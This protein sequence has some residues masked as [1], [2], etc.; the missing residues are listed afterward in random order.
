MFRVEGG[1]VR[2]TSTGYGTFGPAEFKEGNILGNANL[3]WPVKFDATEA[4][5]IL[6]DKGYTG[7]YTKLGLVKPLIPGMNQDHYVFTMMDARDVWIGTNDGKV[8]Q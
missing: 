7:S 8:A 4:D 5:K 2:I 6:K 1:T 3:E